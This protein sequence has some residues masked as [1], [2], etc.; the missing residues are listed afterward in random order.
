MTSIDCVAVVPGGVEAETLAAEARR[1]RVRRRHGIVLAVMV[2]LAAGVAAVLSSCGIGLTQSRGRPPARVAVLGSTINTTIVLWPVG[3]PA[4]GPSGGPPAYVDDLST[5]R[6][7]L[8]GI[9]GIAGGDFQPYLVSVGRWLVYPGNGG[10]SAIPDDLK[11]SPRV[12]GTGQTAAWFVPSARADRVWLVDQTSS[13]HT[14]SVRSA[15]V[16]RP[17]HGSTITLPRETTVVRGTDAG[18]LLLTRSGEL[19]LWNAGARATRIVRLADAGSGFASSARLVAFGTGCRTEEATSG[20]ANGPVGYDVCRILTV[21]DVV[22]D[23]R[24]SFAAPPGT[25]G[26]VPNG[27]G[28]DSAIAPGDAMLAAEA[29][30]APARDGKV[31]LFVLALAGARRRVVPVALSTAPLYARTAWSGDGSWLFYEGPGA[32]RRAVQVTSGVA[33]SYRTPCC[34]YTAMVAVPSSPKR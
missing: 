31:R 21:V 30:V 9:P 10:V 8:R 25:I 22:T 6:L 32:R 12:L 13:G 28:T 1:R 17:E 2:A 33:M 20:Y 7:S 24:F 5:G 26:W 15:R 29:A 16:S 27:F 19:E 34:E 4:F 11:G 3:Y 23:T 18:L 14:P